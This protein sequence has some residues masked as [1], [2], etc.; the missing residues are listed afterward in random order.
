MPISCRR[1]DRNSTPTP[2]F[3][4]CGFTLIEL[5]VVIAIIA[6]LIALLLPAVQQAREA[7]R[8]SQCRNNL[9]QIG[10]AMHNYVDTHGVLPPGDINAGG[11][12]SAWLLS[13]GSR[14]VRN[15]TAH[16]FILP[17]IDQAPLYS[18]IDFSLATGASDGVNGANT[19]GMGGGGYQ[20]ATEVP[21][22]IYSCPSDP[23]RLG[24]YTNASTAYAVRNAYRTSYGLVYPVY[25]MGRSFGAYMAAPT[26]QVRTSAFGHN[27]AARIR[28]FT[29]GTSNSMLVIE[30]PLEKYDDIRGPFWAAYVATGTISPHEY[31]INHPYTATDKRAHHCA[32]GSKHVGGCHLLL[33]DGSVR[34]L[35]ENISMVT[36]RA[37][38]TICGNEVGGEF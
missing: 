33:A 36:Q 20:T 17:Y 8:R 25:G 3:S 31:R 11:Y 4:R 38:V 9:K 19:T 37:L 5:L 22:T 12:D 26:T 1:I 21:I 32:P 35:N 14:F 18:K 7:A 27:G 28:D 16:L 24:P 6:I 29:D 10:L 15:H 2:R 30:T 23:H 13:S 34:F